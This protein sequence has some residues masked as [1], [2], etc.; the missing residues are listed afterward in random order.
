MSLEKNHA[1]EVKQILAKYPSEFKRSA[2]MPLLY[3]GQREEG[4]V[5]KD[6][7]KDI[8]PIL[9][10][11]ET[12]VASIIGFYSLYDDRKADKYRMLVCIDLP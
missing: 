10:I 8:A 2:V 3:L 11:T 5:N 4:F 6:S 12:D 9:V 7:M 1:K